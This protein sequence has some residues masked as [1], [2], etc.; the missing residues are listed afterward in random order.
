M[1]HLNG[2]PMILERVEGL[3]VCDNHKTTENDSSYH[4]S[5]VVGIAAE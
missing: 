2:T 4:R 3:I 1:E 5:R